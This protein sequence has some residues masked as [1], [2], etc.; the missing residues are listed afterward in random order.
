MTGE[1]ICS[2]DGGV[3]TVTLNRP[4]KRNALNGAVLDGLRSTFDRLDGDRNVR[5][6]VVRGA[7]KAFCAG[8]D[9][10]EM[11]ERQALPDDPESGVIEVLRRI[12]ASRHPTVA[13]VQGDAYAGGCELALHCDL[14][15]VAD[16]VR[17]A[18]P[19]AKIGLIV[20]FVLGQKLVEIV[21]PA[22]TREILLTGQPVTA[23]RA[24]EMG[25]V[26]R[27]VAA[28]DLES[29][30]YGMARAIAGNAPLSLAGMKAVIQRAIAARESIEHKDL[31]DQVTRAR[32]SA[33][34]REGV[35][36]MLEKRPAQFRSE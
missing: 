6:V 7:G 21:G 18:M 24:L 25:M 17:F 30:T 3:A 15:V 9:L 4:E 34:A 23:S 2:V 14:R 11:R 12:E 31:D 35:T 16:H 13:M 36:A 28:A 27:V 33:D 8:M 5:V 22:N 1:L 10:N 26:H 20:P 32:K 29:T 19:L